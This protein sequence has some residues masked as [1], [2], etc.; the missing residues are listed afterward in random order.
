MQYK[1][2]FTCKKLSEGSKFLFLKF[3]GARA[4]KGWKPLNYIIVN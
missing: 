4:Q 3:G 2:K 1:T